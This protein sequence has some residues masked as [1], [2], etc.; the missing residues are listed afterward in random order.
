M[1]R[2][3]QTMFYTAFRT[4][5]FLFQEDYSCSCCASPETRRTRSARRLATR[6]WSPQLDGDTQALRQVP[7]AARLDEHPETRVLAMK[8]EGPRDQLRGLRVNP[9]C[10]IGL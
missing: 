7:R 2:T 3:S 6:S 1:C 9:L 8:S 10:I 4:A 5:P